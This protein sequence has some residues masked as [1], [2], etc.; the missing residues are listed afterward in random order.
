MLLSK[1]GKAREGERGRKYQE[2]R[3][4]ETNQEMQH[5]RAEKYM[6]L[7]MKI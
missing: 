3:Q 7:K 6:E 1:W 2:W 5:H 4:R